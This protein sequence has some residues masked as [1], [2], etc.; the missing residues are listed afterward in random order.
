MTTIT[1]Y[2]CDL[3]GNEYDKAL[4]KVSIFNPDT[5]GIRAFYVCQNDMVRSPSNFNNDIANTMGKALPA[6]TTIDG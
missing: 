5:A 3:C 4:M 2:I 1:T 6:L